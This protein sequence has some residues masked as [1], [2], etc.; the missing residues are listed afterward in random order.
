MT[1]N[2]KPPRPNQADTMN[3]HATLNRFYRL[4]WNDRL[5]SYVAVA[6]TAKGRGKRSV[7]AG[8]LAAVFMAA[9]G[10]CAP[11]ALAGPPNP[12]APTQL[13][14]GAQ[15]TAGSATVKQSGTYLDVNQTSNRAV[16]NWNTFNVGAAAQVNYKQP[17]S[18]SATLN[19]VLDS[20]PSQ[21]LGKITA[22][23]QVYFVNP[24]GVYFGKSASVDV[25]A[26][27]ASTHNIKD[28]DF[29]AG[30]M[31]FS[32]DA[33]AG[34]VVNEGDIRAAL[35]GFVALLA[36]EVRNEGVIVAQLGTVALASGEAVSLQFDGE[37]RLHNVTVE[38]S[39]IKALVENKGAVLAPGGLII[40]SARAVDRLQGGVVKNS[41]KLEATGMQMRGGK[42]VLD[43]SD[44]IE[45]SGSINANAAADAS[46]IISPA[47]SIS[48][49][50]PEIV[51]S[52]SISAS[53][54]VVVPPGVT[55]P[56]AVTGGSITLDAASNFTQSAGARLDAS[57]SAGGSIVV[58]A[59]QDI[60]LAGKLSA[61]GVDSAAS[62]G[63][64]VDAQGGSI[65]LVAS[66][67]LTLS[68]ALLDAFGASS[69]GRIHVEAGNSANT[70]KPTDPPAPEDR[71]PTLALTGTTTLRTGS[72]RGR[73]GKVTLAG[74]QIGLLDTT[75]IDAT[76]AT[77]GGTVLVGGDWQG[78]LTE[79]FSYATAQAVVMSETARI[80]VSAQKVPEGTQSAGAGGTAVLWS[81]A[82]TGFYGQ[83]DAKGGATS[84]NGGQVE[85]SSHN[86][87]QA[88]GNVNTSASA[89]QAGNWLLDPWNVTIAG[90]GPSG[91]AYASNFTP[92]AAS[93]ILA[94]SIVTS[95]NAGTSTST[96]KL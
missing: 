6:E 22:N 62:S 76:G 81:E 30:N 29:M 44:R 12:P 85:T 24:N 91:T 37:G 40:L 5:A 93:T 71:R 55:V 74:E 58:Q 28:A 66:G 46:G 51:N 67:N 61:T 78:K 83:I 87:L 15:V 82:Y 88:M 75:L 36:P 73:G 18:S 38:P 50:A 72:S 70:R 89:G 60:V 13:P 47:G 41:G 3:R 34:S 64:S 54:I 49:S 95:L 7:R 2:A 69:G 68:S 17:S 19:R 20:N 25:G 11:Y 65:S 14:T 79:N 1:R 9:A 16:I 94:S 21:I 48:I 4:V 53:G 26:L 59:A 57:G 27:V 43:A 63:N 33:S 10:L 90:S 77:G 35:K 42:I 45:N 56:S 92:T 86:N 52:G 23:G 96:R 80:D 31:K 39:Q 8:A 32:R 84:G